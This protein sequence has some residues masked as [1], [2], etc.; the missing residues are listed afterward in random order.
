MIDMRERLITIREVSQILGISEKEVIELAEKKKI[1]SYL[2]GGEFLRFPQE[3]IIKLKEK[4]Q[5]ELNISERIIPFKE[6][7]YNF[8][9]FNDFYII[10]F[11]IILVLLGIILFT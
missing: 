2:I 8:F 7:I 4:I 10:S 3:E 9:Y 1:P 6:R 11:L 5:K